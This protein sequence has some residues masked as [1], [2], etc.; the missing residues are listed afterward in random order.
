ML[1]VFSPV[2]LATTAGILFKPNFASMVEGKTTE[3][4]NKTGINR[5]RFF[6][7][8]KTLTGK[9]VKKGN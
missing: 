7:T 5:V 6:N 1:L 2:L 4:P 9:D 8:E 3:C